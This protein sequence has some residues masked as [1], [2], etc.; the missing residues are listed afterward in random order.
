MTTFQEISK[1]EHRDDKSL[2]QG[3][4]RALCSGI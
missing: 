2:M 3:H 1:Q 4:I